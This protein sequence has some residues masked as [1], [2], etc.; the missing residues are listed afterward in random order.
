MAKSPPAKP[1]LPHPR[2]IEMA[3]AVAFEPEP[4]A[5]RRIGPPEAQQEVV[6]AVEDR[7]AVGHVG[8]LPG[9][10]P[11]TRDWRRVQEQSQAGGR[12]GVGPESG[13]RR[14]SG[15]LAGG[16]GDVAVLPGPEARV[17]EERHGLVPGR[18]ADQAGG[19]ERRL[20]LLHG[21]LQVAGGQRAAV[22]Q[23]GLAVRGDLVEA[24]AGERAAI[25]RP[26][27]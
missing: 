4:V 20:K 15:G 10:E 8:A 25:R 2:Q 5:G 27:K 12:V 9:L 7:D 13:R 11:G 3:G 18:R 16:G 26:T 21:Q 6:V 19:E 17:V 22:E 14:R 1:P 23:D 24:E